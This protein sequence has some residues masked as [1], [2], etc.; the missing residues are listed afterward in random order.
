MS[1]EITV[2]GSS[3]GGP[4][5]LERTVTGR[6]DTG[7]V[8]KKEVYSYRDDFS[9]MTGPFDIA[10]LHLWNT[11]GLIPDALPLYDG[12][13]QIPTPLCDVLKAKGLFGQPPED[14]NEWFLWTEAKTP[15]HA[16]N[17]RLNKCFLSRHQKSELKLLS[18]VSQTHQI[19]L[20]NFQEFEDFL[21]HNSA[22]SDVIKALG[23]NSFAEPFV[24][25][26]FKTLTDFNC[27]V[28]PEDIRNLVLESDSGAVREFFMR[29]IANEKDALKIFASYNQWRSFVPIYL[30]S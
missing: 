16:L 14:K 25:W 23:L 18:I 12:N 8:R 19:T 7:P 26:I 5:R 27:E 30:V 3:D 29:E 2:E 4:K 13:S 20:N 9:L 11:Y 22:V 10:T 15:F 6:R 1:A 17:A 24:M 28:T 21:E